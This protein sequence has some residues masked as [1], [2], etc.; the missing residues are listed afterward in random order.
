MTD[1]KSDRLH[2]LT[3]GIQGGSG[4]WSV[5]RGKAEGDRPFSRPPFDPKS[6]IVYL[7]P[8]E[9]VIICFIIHPKW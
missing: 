4:K 6:E 5:A 8:K 2:C 7:L 1:Q 3:R 9:L